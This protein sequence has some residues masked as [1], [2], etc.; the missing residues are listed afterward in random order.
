M[1][2]R[3]QRARQHGG[4]RQAGSYAVSLVGSQLQQVG[5]GAQEDAAEAM[6]QAGNQTLQAAMGPAP[7]AAQQTPVS[8]TGED[9]GAGSGHR[10]PPTPAKPSWVHPGRG[11]AQP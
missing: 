6:P 4:P 10:P 3:T 8:A 9:E 7:A 1:A 11:H 2:P 5:E